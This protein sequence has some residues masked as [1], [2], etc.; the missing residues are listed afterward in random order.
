[1]VVILCV[2][3]VGGLVLGTTRIVNEATELSAGRVLTHR[4]TLENQRNEMRKALFLRENQSIIQELWD[5][6]KG[7]GGDIDNQVLSSLES[8][9]M[10]PLV[11]LPPKSIPGN[12]MSYSGIRFGG[13]RTEFQRFLD[14]IALVERR[15]SMIQVQSL[16]MELPNNAYPNQEK[17]TYL[18]ISLEIALPKK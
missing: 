3:F 15:N 7:W 10:E 9:G 12:T 6:V 1:M 16:Q 13:R 17:P 11:K 8:A 2:I 5:S 4:D 14:S 18:N